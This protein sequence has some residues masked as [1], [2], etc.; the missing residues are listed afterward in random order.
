MN[1]C[2]K[3]RDGSH[4]PGVATSTVPLG[5]PQ[6][7]R[8]QTSQN[9]GEI[10]DVAGPAVYGWGDIDPITPP[11]EPCAE[12]ALVLAAASSPD[13][14]SYVVHRLDV[15]V[16]MLYSPEAQRMLRAVLASYL[17]EVEDPEGQLRD[18]RSEVESR[19]FRCATRH[20]RTAVDVWADTVRGDHLCRLALESAFDAAH[21]I[22]DGELRAA[23]AC[24]DQVAHVLRGA[25]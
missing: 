15:D 22:R 6:P 14:C 25:A 4:H 10:R 19:A 9:C 16:S 3:R 8:S 24:A 23:Q 12:F 11:H 7:Y 18:V 5:R 1:V 21:F 13:M 2:E 20:V 17:G